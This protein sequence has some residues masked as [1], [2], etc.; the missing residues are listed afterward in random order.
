MR[1]TALGVAAAARRAELAVSDRAERL[2]GAAFPVLASGRADALH[3]AALVRMAA[4]L[5]PA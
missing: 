4:A 5:R 2:A 3:R 1:V